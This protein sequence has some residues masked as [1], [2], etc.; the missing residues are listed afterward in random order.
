MGAGFVPA[1]KEG[2]LT[3]K[4]TIEAMFASGRATKKPASG[5]VHALEAPVQRMARVREAGRSAR[6]PSTSTPESNS[7]QRNDFDRELLSAPADAPELLTVGAAADWLGV[8]RSLLYRC[9]HSGQIPIEPIVLGN[10]R[11][12]A[13]RQLQAWLERCDLRTEIADAGQPIDGDAIYRDLDSLFESRPASSRPIT[14]ADSRSVAST[15]W[16]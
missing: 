11:Y 14:S 15:N 6:A 4:R 9:L 3:A 8:S 12:I 10:T 13:R 5:H 2:S 16:A 7:S 1:S